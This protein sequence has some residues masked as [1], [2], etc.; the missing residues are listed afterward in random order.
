MFFKLFL[1]FTVIPFVEVTILLQ[2]SKYLGVGSTIFMVLFSGIL[3][4]FFVRREGFSIWFKLQKELQEG[5]I[6]SD[7]IFNGILLL[8]AGIVL[9][10]PGL[11]TDLLGYILIIPFTR[12]AVKKIIVE[13]VKK[14]YSTVS[15]GFAETTTYE[16]IE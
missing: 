9:V 3:G 16:T 15:N 6:P 4:A 2:L 12:E 10:T 5:Q 7:Q 14:K 11:L 1:M 8:I 13:R